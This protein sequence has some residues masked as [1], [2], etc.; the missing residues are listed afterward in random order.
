[1]ATTQVIAEYKSRSNAMTKKTT[2]LLML[3]I[4]LLG[5]MLLMTH[6][7]ARAGSNG[8]Q[9]EV[10]VG[11]WWNTATVTGRNH[12]G[13]LVTWRTTNT[14]LIPCTRLTVKTTGWWWVGTVTIQTT[15]VL[16]RRNVCY[17]NVPRSQSGDWVRVDCVPR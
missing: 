6:Q 14:T 17:P 7:V 12:N 15:G 3:M 4:S 1:M 10:G 9:L 16:G 8:Q 5:V 11:C 2:L 13:T